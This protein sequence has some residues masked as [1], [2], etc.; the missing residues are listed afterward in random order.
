MSAARKLPDVLKT[1][2]CG[3]EYTRA[4]WAQLY[5]V[6]YQVDPEETIE[7]R[8]CACGSTMGIELDKPEAK[9]KV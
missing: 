2:S 8:N 7:L 1:C 4:E 9:E 6:G 5:L 3:R